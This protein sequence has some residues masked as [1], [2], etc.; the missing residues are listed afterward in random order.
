MVLILVTK[1]DLQDPTMRTALPRAF[2]VCRAV[3]AA[4]DS[5]QSMSRPRSMRKMLTC[6]QRML[7]WAK[8]QEAGDV[9]HARS[10]STSFKGMTIPKAGQA[11]SG[12]RRSQR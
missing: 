10:T 5:F 12:S 9:L 3:M 7:P 1:K 6:H 8:S 11:G 4:M 2:G